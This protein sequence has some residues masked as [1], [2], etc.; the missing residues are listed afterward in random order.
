MDSLETKRYGFVG[1]TDSAPL[2]LHDLTDASFGLR[3][4]ITSRLAAR[5]PAVPDLT[6]RV[7][8]NWTRRRGVADGTRQPE[9]LDRAGRVTVWACVLRGVAGAAAP[10]GTPHLRSSSLRCR[11]G[12]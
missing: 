3:F 2:V 6:M 10:E 4:D 7:E 5:N 11:R 8:T 12:W 9:G 1:G